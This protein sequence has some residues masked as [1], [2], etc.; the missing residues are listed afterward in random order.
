MMKRLLLVVAVLYI[1][2]CFAEA[3][4]V[5]IQPTHN[6]QFN[7]TEDANFVYMIIATDPG[8]NYP[9]NFTDTSHDPEIG[10]Y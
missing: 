3:A 4:P 2:V 8:S 9:I 10:F 1:A 6:Q 5:I 7:L